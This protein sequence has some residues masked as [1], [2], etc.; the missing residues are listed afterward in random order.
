MKELPVTGDIDQLLLT[1]SRPTGCNTVQCTAGFGETE[2]WWNLEAGW[3]IIWSRYDDKWAL[4]SSA[5]LAAPDPLGLSLFPFRTRLI[6]LGLAA[7]ALS[8]CPPW[9]WRATLLNIH[10]QTPGSGLGATSSR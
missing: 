7:G 6:D 5:G 8:A 1:D 9:P 10:Q 4:V 2:L 3:R